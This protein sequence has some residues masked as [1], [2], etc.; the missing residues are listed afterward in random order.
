MSKIITLGNSSNPNNDIKIND[1]TVSYEHLEIMW[2]GE[3]QI[4]LKN[5]SNTNHTKVN[6]FLIRESD[7]IQPTDTIVIG[8]STYKGKELIEQVRT[9]VNKDKLNFYDEFQR[10]EPIFKQ[11]RGETKVIKASFKNKTGLFRVSIPLV[12]IV[13]FIAFR[14]T[15]ELDPSLQIVISMASG[16]IAL[17]LSNKVFDEEKLKDTLKDIEI[18]YDRQLRCPKCNRSLKRQP[19]RYWLKERKCEKCKA[20]WVK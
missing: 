20:N 1:K 19:Y 6:N 9:F 4:K 16:G 11:Y 12:V 14:D 13:L 18:K 10:L 17:F 8:Q 7:I 5:L 2:L 3:G 15:L